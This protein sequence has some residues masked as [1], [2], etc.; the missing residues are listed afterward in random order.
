MRFVCYNTQESMAKLLR[1][2][3]PEPVK[4]FLKDPNVFDSKE[5]GYFKSLAQ[6]LKSKN[7]LSEKQVETVEA[8]I[9]VDATK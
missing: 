2:S 7:W 3:I 5:D 9:K 4:K 1:K 8:K 6:Q